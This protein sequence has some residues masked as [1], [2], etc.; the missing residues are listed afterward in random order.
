M[1]RIPLINPYGPKQDGFS[2]PP[3]GL[4]YIAGMLLK[5]GFYVKVVYGCLTAT[6]GFAPTDST[7]SHRAPSRE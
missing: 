6:R 4:L 5:H 2:N 1:E 3:L 7:D